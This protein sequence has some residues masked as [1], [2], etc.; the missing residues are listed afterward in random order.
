M[1][2]C[3]LSCLFSADAVFR[4]AVWGEGLEAPHVVLVGGLLDEAVRLVLGE[5]VV[6]M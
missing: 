3:L 4:V 1:P 5:L 6:Q 2:S